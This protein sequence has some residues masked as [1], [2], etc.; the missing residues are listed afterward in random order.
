MSTLTETQKINRIMKNF[1]WNQTNYLGIPID[2]I[3]HLGSANAEIILNN[4]AGV[5]KIT[6]E[7]REL[8]EEIIN[9]GKRK[10]LLKMFYSPLMYSPSKG[11]KIMFLFHGKWIKGIVSNENDGKVDIILESKNE[12]KIEIKNVSYSSYFI[13]NRLDFYLLTRTIKYDPKF[14]EIFKHDLS[15]Q[16][17]K[18][19]DLD[20]YI[21][22]IERWKY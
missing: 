8:L 20:L 17:R 6:E 22:D 5:G 19:I 4:P 15:F 21:Q 18:A 2:C 12:E 13:L 7:E 16:N 1:N 11:E 3:P 14:W 9:E 10:P